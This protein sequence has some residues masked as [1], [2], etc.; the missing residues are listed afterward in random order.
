M[1]KNY[2]CSHCGNQKAENS[3][4]DIKNRVDLRKTYIYKTP[5]TNP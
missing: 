2:R 1:E 3:I 5:F 4:Y